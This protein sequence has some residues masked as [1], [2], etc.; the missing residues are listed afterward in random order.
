MKKDLW[1]F[2]ILIAIVYLFFKGIPLFFKNT[3]YLYT[4][5][6]SALLFLLWR[7]SSFCW[8][9]E[10]ISKSG[11]KS[12]G[13]IP[14]I[15]LITGWN[16]T[17]FLEVLGEKEEIHET[18]LSLLCLNPLISITD[19]DQGNRKTQGIPHLLYE[20]KKRNNCVLIY[21]SNIWGTN[22][23]VNQIWA[24]FGLKVWSELLFFFNLKEATFE[25]FCSK[26]SLKN[27]SYANDGLKNFC[28]E[29]SWLCKWIRLGDGS[30]R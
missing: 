25:S 19:W 3:L 21:F 30:P 7:I 1:K 12:R 14:N 17:E 8:R 26:M 16:S 20:D 2:L 10:W 28:L 4:A 24:F 15:C 13:L 9:Y 22:R 18:H 23:N 5:R 11:W 6:D 29:G 27:I